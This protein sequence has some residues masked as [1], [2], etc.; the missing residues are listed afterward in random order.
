M[1]KKT[2]YHPD[3]SPCLEGIRLIPVDYKPCCELF[4]SHTSACTYDIRYEWWVGK[5]IWVIAISEQAGGG[6]IEISFCPHCG[7]RL[8]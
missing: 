4:D 6:G 8:N 1:R 2:I 5:N 7:A 3:G